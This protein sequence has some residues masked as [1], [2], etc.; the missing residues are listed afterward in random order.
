MAL[1]L[2]GF[3]PQSTLFHFVHVLTKCHLLREVVSPNSTAT[4]LPAPLPIVLLA[5]ILY[6]SLSMRLAQPLSYALQDG[7]PQTACEP[8]E[9]RHSSPPQGVRG[10]DGGP[11]LAQAAGPSVLPGSSPLPSPFLQL[12]P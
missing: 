11:P 5:L 8:Q 4:P 6:M 9:T 3:S 1:C 12:R 10:Q 2:A 7:Q